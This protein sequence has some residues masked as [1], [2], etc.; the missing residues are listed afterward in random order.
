MSK[1]VALTFDDGPNV[2]TTPK[3]IEKL[4]KYNVT[5]SFFL[6]GDSITAET[7]YL[8]KKEH[9]N[10]YEIANH[11][12][13]HSFMSE[14]SE[15]TI[16]EEI[17]YTSDKIH[18]IIGEY[19]RFFRPPYINMNRTMVNAIDMPFICGI[20]GLDWDPTVDAQKR[21]ELIMENMEDGAIILMHDLKGNDA[22][23]EALD[24]LIPRLLEEGYEFVTISDVFKKKNIN[25]E[26]HTGKLYSNSLHAPIFDEP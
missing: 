10:G 26:I 19:P 6:I 14:F 9:E 16:K 25:P 18:E 5:A 11:S 23:V 22:T 13:T 1:I 8:V 2:E 7:E 21:Y 12:K 17:K 15:E 24:L 4:E 3:V 20:N